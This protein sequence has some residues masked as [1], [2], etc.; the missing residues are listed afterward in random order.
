MGRDAEH[1]AELLAE[2]LTLAQA[3]QRQDNGHGHTDDAEY[4]AGLERRPRGRVSTT[5]RRTQAGE[6]LQVVLADQAAIRA[7]A[8]ARRAPWIA[9]GV[10]AAAGWAA[11]GIGELAWAGGGPAG[12][13]IAAPVIAGLCIA[14]TGLLWLI[15]GSRIP[16]WARR[17]VLTGAGGASAWVTTCALV[18]AN[19][20]TMTALLVSG[21]AA[22]SARWLRE[23]AVPDPARPGPVVLAEPLPAGP[24]LVDLGDELAQRWAVN[25]AH[26]RGAVPGSTLTGRED[27]PRAIRWTVETPPG[28]TSFASLFAQRDKIAAGLRL[29]LSKVLLE[30][31]EVDESF[32]TLTVITR[33]LLAGG[34]PFPGPRYERR[35]DGARVVPLGPYA[36][37]SGDGEFVAVDRVG[38][39]SGL[40]TGEPGSGK[41]ASLEAITMGLKSSGEWAAWFGDGDPD[42]GSSPLLNEM[43]DWAEA[44]PDGV[45]AQLEAVEAALR[46][47]GMLKATLTEGPDGNPVPITDPATQRP[48]RQLLPCPA[49]PGL[50][51]VLDELHRLTT[52]PRLKD[53]E[54]FVARLERVV[55]IGRKYGVVVLAGTQSL[56]VGD[57]GNSTPLRGY[58]S[59]RNLFA[60]RNSNKNE[61]AVV[62]GLEIS[63]SSLP[64]GAGYAFAAGTGRLAM[65]RAAWSPDMSDWLPELSAAS[66]DHDTDLATSGYRPAA[67]P[68]PMAAHAEQLA[69]LDAW[70][71]Q[72]QPGAAPVA[73]GTEDELPVADEAISTPELAGLRAPA[74]LTADNVI[75]LPPP[76]AR[77]TKRGRAGQADIHAPAGTPLPQLNQVP[78]DPEALPL[79]QQKVLAALRKGI[80]R[81]G[82]IAAATGL[83]TPAVSKALA[84]LADLGLAHKRAHGDWAPGRAA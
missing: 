41:S 44:G 5:A 53:A 40:L 24:E 23:H 77:S 47:R 45:L 20:W 83:R 11:T 6:D 52:D 19:S 36:D 38:C 78:A 12:G 67:P 35:D 75:T 72:Q 43:S 57:F 49:Y 2:V 61:K 54:K 32:A 73:P 84:A 21:A 42:G 74:P 30:P 81:T 18:G 59:A 58:L 7:G 64:A 48:L 69:R 34:I 4:D 62:A 39:R 26:P 17:R 56:L 46:V 1:A 10:T 76:G 3:S 82:E 51:W 14:A 63:P 16:R 29:G 68:D 60:F 9:T 13:A 25:I 33:D 22:V 71:A 8:R 37:G 55:R 50:M 28:S 80:T 31:S 66:L 15:C 65:L 70:R 27:L 79:A